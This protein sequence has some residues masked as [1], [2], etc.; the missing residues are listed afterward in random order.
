MKSSAP[1]MLT[2]GKGED[3][4]QEK[5]EE[6]L[7]EE[8][9]PL[10]KKGKVIITNPPK[11]STAVFIRRSKR[12]GSDNVLSK[13]PLMFQEILKLI[14]EGDGIKKFKSLK[15]ETRTKDKKKQV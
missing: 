1:L 12:K 8:E 3:E 11:S 13:P 10:K 6:E 4:D 14:A 7:E 2:E 15:Y 9:E 5:D